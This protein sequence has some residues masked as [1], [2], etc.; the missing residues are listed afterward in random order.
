MAKITKTLKTVDTLIGF[1]YPSD[2]VD[3]RKM[4]EC[5]I[6][7]KKKPFTGKVDEFKTCC[8]DHGMMMRQFK[9]LGY[10]LVYCGECG[11]RTMAH[12]KFKGIIKYDNHRYV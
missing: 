11:K 3:A 7:F 12:P 8:I 4:F 5:P 6:C 1:Y 10:E 2:K 9:K